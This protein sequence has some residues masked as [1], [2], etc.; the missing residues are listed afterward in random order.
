MLN[1]GGNSKLGNAAIKAICTHLAELTELQIWETGLTGTHHC[2]TNTA[3]NA[4][5]FADITPVC[6]LV[7][8]KT[9]I[10]GSEYGG[11]PLKKLPDE[12][13]NLVALEKLQV[14]YCQL[15]GALI[16]RTNT[17]LNWFAF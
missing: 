1:V 17:T 16:C 12:I 4:F 2:R 13:K 15:E 10:L 7:G 9:L 3:V 5:L 8:L 6:N 14:P 11:N